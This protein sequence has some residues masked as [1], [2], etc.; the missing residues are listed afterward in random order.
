[1][2]TRLAD[3]T[4]L[5][6]GGPVATLV[7]VESEA[8]FIDAVRA[9]DA[10]STRS[11]EPAGTAA[12]A[13]LLV[14]GGG[15]NVLAGDGPFAGTVVRDRRTAIDVESADACGG[16]VVRVSAGT[17]WEHV[18]DAAIAEGWMGIECLTGIPGSTGAT[19][20]QNVGAYGQ[21]IAEVVSTVRCW[22]RAEQRVRTFAAGELG[23]G[24]R[25]S[26]LKSSLGG[27]WGVTPRYVVLEVS[28]Q[29]RL[30]TLSAPIRYAELAAALD[31]P[32]GG[33][34]DA[35]RVRS[36]VRA[37]RAGKGMV[38]D[39]GDHDTWSAGSFFTNPIVARGLVPAGAPAFDVPGSD[40]VKTSAAWLIA[41]AGLER[42]FGLGGRAA[43]SGKHVLA[44]TNRGG[45]SAAE[46]LDLARAVRARV[47]GAFGITLVPEPVLVGV[48]LD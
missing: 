42:G 41:R 6:V 35:A 22:D 27:R 28:F 44:L 8:E 12:G 43:L 3:L 7:D 15:S 10:G 37:L 21:E 19:P 13:G 38:L 46:L 48:S 2:S 18:V 20:V 29:F 1:M 39:D 31:E 23:F 32:L 17:P 30:A 26:L 25:S 33:R 16:A 34:T 45:A 47:A 5:R 14:L 24:Y 11:A 4:T 36:A 40:L 9:A